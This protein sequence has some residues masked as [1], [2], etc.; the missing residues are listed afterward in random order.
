MHMVMLRPSEGILDVAELRMW[1][2]E[3]SAC[4]GSDTRSIRAPLRGGWLDLLTPGAHYLDPGLKCRFELTLDAS[5]PRPFRMV[6]TTGDGRGYDFTAPS[7]RLVFEGPV[8][9]DQCE[10]VL[11]FDPDPILESAFGPD[12]PTGSM[13]VAGGLAGLALPDA[14][15][16]GSRAEAEAVYG[17]R[18][19]ALAP[20][21]P[22]QGPARCAAA[23]PVPDPGPA[24][25]GGAGCASAGPAGPGLLLSLWGLLVAAR[26][27]RRQ[28]PR[29]DAP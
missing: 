4:D 20:S 5:D 9:F 19:A 12:N 25:Q 6:G 27:R 18:W 14:L 13:D 17:A 1:T 15:W 24:A 23:P 29:A 26:R 10:Q 8:A 28:G 11:L 7:P 3:L 2:F 16:L 21:D 22:I